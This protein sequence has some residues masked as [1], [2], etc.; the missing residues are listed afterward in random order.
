[1]TARKLKK[2]RD[3]FIL[4]IFMQRNEIRPAFLSEGTALTINTENQSSKILLSSTFREGLPA[5]S[6]CHTRRRYETGYCLR[7]LHS[8]QD[9]MPPDLQSPIAH[10]GDPL[11]MQQVIFFFT[12]PEILANDKECKPFVSS[13]VWEES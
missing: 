4:V 6:R 11:I 10:F 13:Y 8:P 9:G 2:N 1:M 7:S 12:E 3:Q 5:G